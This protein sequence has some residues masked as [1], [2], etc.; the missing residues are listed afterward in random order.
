[1]TAFAVS[2]AAGEILPKAFWD[3]RASA[4][5]N[6]SI[7]AVLP[8]MLGLMAT[9]EPRSWRAWGVATLLAGAGWAA[10]A[11]FS[12]IYIDEVFVGPPLSVFGAVFMVTFLPI[13]LI[14]VLAGIILRM[15]RLTERSRSRSTP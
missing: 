7:W 5:A 12:A 6:L 8:L 10:A 2:L 15:K 14:V 9:T 11:A 3:A 4:V 1:M 13:V